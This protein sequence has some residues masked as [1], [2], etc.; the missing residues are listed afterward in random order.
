MAFPPAGDAALQALAHVATMATAQSQVPIVLVPQHDAAFGW[1]AGAIHPMQALETQYQS[2]VR[3]AERLGNDP[4][5][6]RAFESAALAGFYFFQAGPPRLLGAERDRPYR[7]QRFPLPTDA[8]RHARAELNAAKDMYNAGIPAP[9]LTTRVADARAAAWR[10]CEPFLPPANPEQVNAP[11]INQASALIQAAGAAP[12]VLTNIGNALT[13]LERAVAGDASV[14]MFYVIE[15]FYLSRLLVAYRVR[16]NTPVT[17]DEVVRAS[18]A[19]TGIL[20]AQAWLSAW[21]ERAMIDLEFAISEVD[22]NQHTRFFL[23]G[24][25]ALAYLF[26]QPQNAR[27]DWDTQ[28][29]IDPNLAPGDWYALYRDVSNQVLLTLVRMK[30][31]FYSI[32]SANAAALQALPVPPPAPPDPFADDAPEPPWD[33]IDEAPDVPPSYENAFTRACK[34]ELIDIGMPR[35]DTIELREQWAQLHNNIIRP[36]LGMP[37]PGYAYYVDEYV[38]MIRE[39]FADESRSPGKARKRI[40]RLAELLDRDEAAVVIVHAMQS[41]PLTI[42]NVVA[43]VLTAFVAQQLPPAQEALRYALIVLLDEFA[44]A[45]E[46]RSDPGLAQEFAAFFAGWMPN[47]EVVA[48]YPPNFRFTLPVNAA[49]MADA[50][51]FGQW[52]SDRLQANFAGRA[53]LIAAHRDA[54]E[55]LIRT[56]YDDSVFNQQSEYDVQLAIGGSLGARLHAEY[57]N[58]ANAQLEQV[59]TVSIGLYFEGAHIDAAT[60]MELVAPLVRNYIAAQPAPALFYLDET[61]AGTL[62][63]FW[64]DPQRIEP[65]G[66]YHPLAIEIVAKRV[67]ERPLLS[68]I[69]GLPV[70]GLRDLIVEYQ[71]R[72]AHIVEY[73]RRKE[74]RNTAAALTEMLMTARA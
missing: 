29:L 33:N 66:A 39:F 43:P 67:R 51:G 25:R 73:S 24:G 30:D 20:N 1:E 14:Q 5:E 56:V 22:P 63:I 8:L 49:P 47:Q 4:I 50:I 18:S 52:M 72:A 55:A 17:E 57:Q 32:L 15:P 6:K 11:S 53:A 46:M 69:W 70:L 9:L 41:I 16:S 12:A 28:I 26:G 64:A 44:I 54:V 62:R 10:V 58:A 45:Y 31:E 36:T 34:A 42:W 48:D 23:K 68:F 3:D 2:I 35:R 65:F 60:A 13:L 61:M 27:N 59:A 40:E 38:T 7:G 19:L 37:I 74:L 21:L 71:T